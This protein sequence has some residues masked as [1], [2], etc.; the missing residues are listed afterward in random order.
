MS[1]G[2]IIRG[3]GRNRGEE[4]DFPE[5]TSGQLVRRYK[6]FLADVRLSATGELISA[7]CPNTGAMTGCQPPGGRVWLSFCD[8]P[9]R[10][11]NWTW[12]LVET[13]SGLICV[14]A[15]LANRLVAEAIEHGF[16][17]S[18]WPTKAVWCREKPLSARSR[19]DFFV[20]WKGGIFVEVKA[21]SLHL[22]KGEGAFPDSVSARATK[23]LVELVAARQQGYRVL[24]IFCVMHTG[25]SRISPA[26]RIDPVYAGHL[27]W[28]I[29]NGLEVYAL[30]NDI[31][32]AGIYPRRL[33][34]MQG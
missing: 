32:T 7:H 2:L 26:H 10:K 33:V 21:V 1:Q 12:E 3:I 27:Q 30:F 25:I 34:S 5:L 6:R 11:L 28:A 13:D 29:A 17:S 22:D 23:H 4:M 16:F 15:A 19:A 18:L 20:E 24:L 31:S 14:H 8:S 9:H